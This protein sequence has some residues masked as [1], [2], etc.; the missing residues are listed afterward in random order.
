M[1]ALSPATSSEAQEDASEAYSDAESI[2]SVETCSTTSGNEAVSTSGEAATTFVPSPAF[3]RLKSLL[4]QRDRQLSL[5]Q[6]TEYGPKHSITT[7]GAE[8][9]QVNDVQCT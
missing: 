6:L 9:S 1:A 4:Q 7:P 2:F 3:A 8:D 5:D